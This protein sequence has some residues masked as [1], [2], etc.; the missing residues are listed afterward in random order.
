MHDMVGVSLIH[1]WLEFSFPIFVAHEVLDL[2][3]LV[4]WTITLKLRKLPWFV[5]LE[6]G[7]VFVTAQIH[8]KL[9]N[10]SCLALIPDDVIKIAC[11]ADMLEVHNQRWC[12]REPTLALSYDLFEFRFCRLQLSTCISLLLSHSLEFRLVLNRLDNG[13]IHVLWAEEL[14][15]KVLPLPDCHVVLSKLIFNIIVVKAW[16]HGD[17]GHKGVF[18]LRSFVGV[19]FH[20]SSSLTLKLIGLDSAISQ[21][22]N[23]TEIVELIGVLIGQRGKTSLHLWSVKLDGALFVR[24]QDN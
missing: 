20:L 3:V 2:H 12:D 19:L 7:R 17:C 5:G 6:I 24:W 4:L 9:D 18:S 14:L 16:R 11:V 21:C 1:R 23:Q 8:I 22:C 13:Y 15:L 10:V